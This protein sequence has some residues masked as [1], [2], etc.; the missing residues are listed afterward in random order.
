MYHLLYCS[1]LFIPF[2]FISCSF[3]NKP[4]FDIHPNSFTGEK[5]YF[6]KL[7]EIYR[8]KKSFNK[9][10]SKLHSKRFRPYRRFLG[11]Q[12]EV[13]GSYNNMNN[14]YLV[15]Q[16]G[17]GHNYK[18][19][20][21]AKNDKNYLLPSYIVS[22]DLFNKAKSLI[23]KIV[24]LNDVSDP[25]GF[26]PIADYKFKRYAPVNVVDV[27]FY[28]N[29]DT[30]YPIWLKVQTKTGQDALVRF[31]DKEG[32]PGYKDHYFL[33]N[34]LPAE[35][36]ENI[37]KMVKSNKIEIGM[38]ER[39]IK[40]SIGNPDEIHNTSSIHGISDQWIYKNKIGEKI[41]FQFEYGKL[42]YINE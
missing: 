8:R 41:Y 4:T 23:G 15:I 27:V 30:D 21:I 29:S 7:D 26:S 20:W 10:W 24:W 33:D 16:D 42:L 36:G 39:Q 32:K 37:I 5:I 18:M 14:Y 38:T 31:N 40:V 1:R 25:L 17:K 34:P 11:K 19:D 2:L 35:W 9:Q 22:N 6:S 3:F 28:Q 13:V 12:F